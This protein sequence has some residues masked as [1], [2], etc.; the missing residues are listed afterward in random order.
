[1]VALKSR[2]KQSHQKRIKSCFRFPLRFHRSHCT[3]YSDFGFPSRPL[4]SRGVSLTSSAHLPTTVLC[5][6]CYRISPTK[7]LRA[8]S[9]RPAYPPPYDLKAQTIHLPSPPAIIGLP[10]RSYRFVF[11]RVWDADNHT[12]ESRAE[13]RA[14]DP[15]E[16]PRIKLATTLIMLKQ[17]SPY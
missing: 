11:I 15:R 2:A 5:L 4:F 6:V 16:R 8:T 13:S 9:L 10:V 1:V 17:T 14:R 3:G 7:H 12:K